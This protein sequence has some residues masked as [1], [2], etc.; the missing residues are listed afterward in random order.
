MEIL[1]LNICKDIKGEVLSSFR[2]KFFI[3][4]L[5][6]NFGQD[7]EAEIIVDISRQKLN[8]DFEAEFVQ[9]FVAL[10]IF[11]TRVKELYG[12][13]RESLTLWRLIWCDSG[14]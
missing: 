3:K 5:K 11:L 10:V 12:L 8:W 1:N 13:V 9:D 14:Q 6:L 4:T 2:R 7:F